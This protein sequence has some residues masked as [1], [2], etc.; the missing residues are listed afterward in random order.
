LIASIDAQCRELI[1][2]DILLAGDPERRE[3]RLGRDAHLLQVSQGVRPLGDERLLV[4][5]GRAPGGK[6]NAIPEGLRHALEHGVAVGNRGCGIAGDADHVGVE[7]LP[8]LVGNASLDL[9]R[10]HHV[11]LEIVEDA[12]GGHELAALID[13]ALAAAIVAPGRL[14]DLGHAGARALDRLA[15]AG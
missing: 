1:E 13:D 8:I 15:A 2:P 4:A 6:V 3:D 9:D 14:N 5:D 11:A 10:D 7:A 12:L